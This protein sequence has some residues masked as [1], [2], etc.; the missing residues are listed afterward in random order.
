MLPAPLL[1]F[2][3]PP[4]LSSASWRGPG[5]PCA[6]N[7]IRPRRV[8]PHPGRHSPGPHSRH[9]R[10]TK[11]PCSWVSQ[12]HFQG[13]REARLPCLPARP[14]ALGCREGSAPSPPRKSG[15]REE[16]PGPRVPWTWPQPLLFPTSRARFISVLKAKPVA[17]GSRRELRAAG[18]GGG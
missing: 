13:L 5:L 16:L 3:P 8:L 1:P 6:L 10:G 7:L 18:E 14:P 11:A 12:A 15:V 9:W 2:L 4:A 17:L